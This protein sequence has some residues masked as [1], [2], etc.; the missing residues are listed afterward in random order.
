MGCRA[1]VIAEEWS[2]TAS[3]VSKAM[4]PQFFSTFY[5]KLPRRFHGIVMPSL[6][7]ASL[8]V[9]TERQGKSRHAVKT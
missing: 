6:A 5:G 3:T 7:R 8:T 9:Q 4:M 1:K 2:T